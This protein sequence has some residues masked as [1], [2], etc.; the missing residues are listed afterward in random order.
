MPLAPMKES[1]ALKRRTASGPEVF[2]TPPRAV[3]PTAPG[4]ATL[5][6]LNQIITY[7]AYPYGGSVPDSADADCGGRRREQ[8]DE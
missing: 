2:T 8:M 7:D 4:Y 3:Y 1:D 5:R 6:S